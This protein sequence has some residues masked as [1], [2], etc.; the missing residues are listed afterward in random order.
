M[1]IIMD[2]LLQKINDINRI[3][4][5][6]DIDQ[7]E[8]LHGDG[9]HDITNFIRY[10]RNAVCHINNDKRNVGNVTI[11]FM[12]IGGGSEPS[13]IAGRI[14]VNKYPDDACIVLGTKQL[15]I[16]RHLIKVYE[17]LK[18]AYLAIPEFEQLPF[19]FR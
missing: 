1:L 8:E 9:L 4:F 19:L 14:I 17:E 7:T 5:Q 3:S 15:Y 13:N 12:M 6:D 2:D 11:S 10:L 16:K 18:T